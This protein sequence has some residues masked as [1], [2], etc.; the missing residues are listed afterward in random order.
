MNKLF[1]NELEKAGI[2]FNE[3]DTEIIVPQKKGFILEE[4]KMYL[5]QL[6]TYMTN[7]PSG[8]PIVVNWNQNK[9]PTNTYY[10]VDVTKIMG[11]MVK[12]NGMAYDYANRCDLSYMWC[13]WI[14]KSEFEILE[15]F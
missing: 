12:V 5:I 2:E 1:K 14:P 9:V 13:G 10:K 4:N 11:N 7:P 8:D 6:S 15:K 3:S